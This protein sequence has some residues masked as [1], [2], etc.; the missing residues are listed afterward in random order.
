MPPLHHHFLKQPNFSLS[1]GFSE[2]MFEEKSERTSGIVA[3]HFMN[4]D[5]KQ[6]NVMTQMK[7]LSERMMDGWRIGAPNSS[8]H[9]VE[10]ATMNRWTRNA[11]KCLAC[12]ASIFPQG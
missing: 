9:L 8:S 1:S 7:D 11:R 4:D 10:V 5:C 2:K 12:S 3:F 6:A